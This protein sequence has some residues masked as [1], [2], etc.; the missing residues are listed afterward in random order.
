MV[1]S[2]EGIPVGAEGRVTGTDGE[3]GPTIDWDR[4]YGSPAHIN[5]ED[6]E[7]LPVCL[8]DIFLIR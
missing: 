5:P 3:G 2:F 6:V 7:L 8:R 1:K 4:G